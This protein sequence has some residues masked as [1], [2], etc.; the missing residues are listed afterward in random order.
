MIGPYISLAVGD[1][2]LYLGF[3]T[4][5]VEKRHRSPERYGKWMKE[6][7]FPEPNEVNVYLQPSASIRRTREK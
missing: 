3:K 6:Y 5:Q 4:F 1:L 7:E 2:G